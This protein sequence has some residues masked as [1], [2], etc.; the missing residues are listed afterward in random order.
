MNP[1]KFL[2]LVTHLILFNFNLFY[3]ILF[4][5]ILKKTKKYLLIFQNKKI[6]FFLEKKNKKATNFA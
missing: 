1:A 2:I 4:Y 3:F 5:F 6:M